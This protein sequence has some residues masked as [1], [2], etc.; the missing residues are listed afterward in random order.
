MLSSINYLLFIETPISSHIIL[1]S[2]FLF[3]LRSFIWLESWKKNILCVIICLRTCIIPRTYVPWGKFCRL[4]AT[5][6]LFNRYVLSE[7]MHKVFF[8]CWKV[9]FWLL[10]GFFYFF[11]IL[12]K[13]VPVISLRTVCTIFFSLLVCHPFFF[14]LGPHLQHMEG[15]RLGGTDAGLRHSH[16]N[17]G[18]K[19]HLRPSLQLTAMP[20]V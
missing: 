6:Q 14:L 13:F 4:P 17:V 10:Q 1:F 12:I 5:Y 18:Y 15:P 3:T 11:C 20:D 16:S 19:P 8:P 2:V 7:W 9:G